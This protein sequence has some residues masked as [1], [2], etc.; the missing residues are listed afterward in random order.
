VVVAF[1]GVQSLDVVGPVEAFD[2]AEREVPGSYVIDVVGPGDDGFVT[3]S[4]GLRLG[5]AGR[6][7]RRRRR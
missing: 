1:E 3:M 2:Y 5:A 7:S 6:H 4:N